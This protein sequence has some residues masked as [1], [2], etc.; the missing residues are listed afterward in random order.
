VALQEVAQLAE[1][2]T[3]LTEKVFAKPS[4]W[5]E[6]QQVVIVRQETLRKRTI[7]ICTGNRESGDTRH[8]A[9]MRANNGE[10]LLPAF[11]LERS[12]CAKDAGLLRV[13]M[14]SEDF[15]R[16]ITEPRKADFE[17][18]YNKAHLHGL[19][20]VLE[21]AFEQCRVEVASNETTRGN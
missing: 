20:L 7:V 12:G 8:I 9:L 14:N 5:T 10:S 15:D 17:L 11:V 18:S 1:T 21:D 4:E 13:Q 16:Y 3:D 19:D 2:I 6:D